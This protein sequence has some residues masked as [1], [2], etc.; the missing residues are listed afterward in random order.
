MKRISQVCHGCEYYLPEVINQPKLKGNCLI[1]LASMM[2]DRKS[3]PPEKLDP[4]SMPVDCSRLM[5]HLVLG[6][7]DAHE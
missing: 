6:Q 1:I 3:F 2:W 7:K 5:E 4:D